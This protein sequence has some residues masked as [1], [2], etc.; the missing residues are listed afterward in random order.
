MLEATIEMNRRRVGSLVVL[1]G[2]RIAGIFTERDVL[3]KVVAEDLPPSRVTVGQVMSREIICC[4]PDTDIDDASEIMRA[5]RVRHLPVCD[6]DG[7]LLGLVSIGDL[8]AYYASSRE[9]QIQHL[10][11]YVYGRA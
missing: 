5:R 3:L 6:G 11:N 8:N 7:R 4:A 1:D 9:V 2:E 10:H